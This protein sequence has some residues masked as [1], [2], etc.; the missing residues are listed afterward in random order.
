MKTLDFKGKIQKKLDCMGLFIYNMQGLCRYL[1]VFV[2]VCYKQ[3]K[4][5]DVDKSWS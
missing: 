1:H 2:R 3:R 4:R 5:M